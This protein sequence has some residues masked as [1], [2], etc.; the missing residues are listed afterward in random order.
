VQLVNEV[1]LVKV[2]V[3]F[4]DQTIVVKLGT[5]APA[6]MFIAP[7]LEQVLMSV[8]AIAELE[9]RIVS[10]LV[11]I[12]LVQPGFEAVNVNITLLAAMSAILGA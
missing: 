9:E 5:L 7:E 11:S 6:V 12:A 3:P 1:S 8:P 10:T 2:P 4:D